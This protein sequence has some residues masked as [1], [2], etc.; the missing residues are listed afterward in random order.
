MVL[1]AVLVC[2]RLGWWQWNRSHD[3]DGT[4][5]NLGYA[6]LWPCFGGAFIFM[7]IRFLKLETIREAEDQDLIESEL[8]GLDDGIEVGAG[9]DT[10]LPRVISTTHGP[11]ASDDRRDAD[12]PTDG[13]IADRDE[14]D[15]RTPRGAPSR[16][17]TIAVASV[18]DDDIDDPELTAYNQALA[19]L[20]DKDRRRAR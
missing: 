6:V 3:A 12:A 19:A 7:W 20:A 10:D 18:S 8:A 14:P 17:V 9:S 5:Q 1:L 13:P 2:L 15:Q 11:D 16:G 4:V